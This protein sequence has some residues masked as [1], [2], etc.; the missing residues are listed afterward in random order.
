MFQFLEDFPANKWG[1]I[2][3]GLAFVSVITNGIVMG[4]LDK[5]GK[6][7]SDE[8]RAAATSLIISI[9]IGAIGMFV[10]ARSH[11]NVRD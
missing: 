3:F 1:L 5:A 10:C 2:I 8:Y 4:K 9:L 6:L 11:E 7:D